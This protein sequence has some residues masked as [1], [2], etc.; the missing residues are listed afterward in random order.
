M[1]EKQKKCIYC[2]KVLPLSEFYKNITRPDRHDILCKEC[3]RTANKRSRGSARDLDI[4]NV[5]TQV[6]VDE[7]RRRGVLRKPAEQNTDH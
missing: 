1:E 3:R 4:V 5:P 7:L 2:K 6:L